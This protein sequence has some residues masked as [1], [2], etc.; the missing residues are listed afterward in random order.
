M[1]ESET[2]EETLNRISKNEAFPNG[3]H[4]ACKCPGDALK[5]QLSI[6]DDIFAHIMAFMDPLHDSCPTSRGDCSDAEL[7][8]R[9]VAA[10]TRV[11]AISK[12]LDEVMK[13]TT[14]HP[15]VRSA[16]LQISQ[17]VH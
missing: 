1:A 11:V 12:Q 9:R 13:S 10:A 4:A 3:L 17:T 5:Q 2:L 15:L 16:A 7:A 14:Q 6:S 8:A